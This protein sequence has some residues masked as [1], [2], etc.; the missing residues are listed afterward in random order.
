MAYYLIENHI[1]PN[2]VS[3]KGETAL[4]EAIRKGK[5]N[6][7]VKLIK[8]YA[9]LNIQNKRGKPPSFGMPKRQFG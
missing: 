7:V 3:Q 8:H 2:I 5:L 6:L 9:N 4:F 1:N